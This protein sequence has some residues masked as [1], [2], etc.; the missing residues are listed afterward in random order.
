MEWHKTG[1]IGS[2]NDENESL[3]SVEKIGVANIEQNEVVVYN[4]ARYRAANDQSWVSRHS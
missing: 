1:G 2:E 4:S 3:R